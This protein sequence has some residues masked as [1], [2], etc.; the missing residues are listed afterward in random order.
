MWVSERLYARLSFILSSIFSFYDVTYHPHPGD[1]QTFIISPFGGGCLPGS[2]DVLTVIN[3]LSHN[4]MPLSYSVLCS[5]KAIST[6][7]KGIFVHPIAV[8]CNPNIRLLPP[9]FPI[10]NYSLYPVSSMCLRPLK[11]LPYYHYL[12]LQTSLTWDKVTSFS[13]VSLL[14]SYSH[15]GSLSLAV[16]SIHGTEVW[17]ILRVRLDRWDL[18]MKV[19]E[20]IKNAHQPKLHLRKL[21]LRIWSRMG[22]F[23]QQVFTEKIKIATGKGIDLRSLFT[24]NFMLVFLPR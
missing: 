19:G 11:S 18:L 9:I 14:Q 15:S 23:N 13:L 12:V 22:S 10:S 17:R 16:F 7:M 1:F 4:S 3:R 6:L 8:I 2:Q 20:G 21:L 5:P 24:T